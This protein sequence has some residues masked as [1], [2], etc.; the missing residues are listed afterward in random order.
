M[1]KCLDCEAYQK[2]IQDKDQEIGELRVKLDSK[3]RMISELS[4]ELEVQ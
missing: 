2:I 4:E 1:E 3:D